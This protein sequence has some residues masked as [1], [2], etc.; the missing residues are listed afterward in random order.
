MS[1]HMTVV[2]LTYERTEYALRTIDGVAENLRYPN[3]S[4]YVADD[5]SRSEHHEAVLGRLEERR[6]K[7]IGQHNQHMSYG[8]GANAGVR[9]AHKHGDLVLML[10]DDWYLNRV[11]DVWHYCAVLMQFPDV[12]MIRMGY[13]NSGVGAL[14]MTRNGELYWALDD[15]HSRNYSSFRFAGHPS[16]IHKRLFEHYGY[17]PEKW[18]PGET[19]L[20]MCWQLTPVGPNVLWPADLGARGPWDHI[21]AKQSY[22]W[23]GGRELEL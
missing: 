3:W 23:N 12:C 20:K 13:L 21:G 8:G 17:Y 7:V 18:Q 11:F 1:E 10:E 15:T 4:W 22:D 9:E 2:L 5:G 16:I 19:E 6:Q 14:S